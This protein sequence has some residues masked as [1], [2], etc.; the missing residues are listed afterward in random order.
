MKNYPVIRVIV[1][2]ICGIILQQFITVGL[3]FF[4]VI[5]FLA[6]V[7]YFIY[8]KSLA[9]IKN[10]MI[11]LLINTLFILAG[12]H[13][14]E[15]CFS[16]RQFY[17]GNIEK[18]NSFTL[19][20]TVE[21][22]YLI[23]KSGLRFEIN[24]DSASVNKFM[25][26]RR[27][28]LICNVKDE[29]YK[30][31][32]SLYSSV[33]PG[34]KI[35]VSGTLIKGRSC[36][37]PGEFDY[38]K[39]LHLYGITG[40]LNVY[41]SDDFKILDHS[42]NWCSDLLF[43]VRKSIAEKLSLYHDFDAAS[44][45]KGLLLADRSEMNDE[46]KIEFVNAGVVHVLAVSGLNVEYILLL[47]IILLGRLNIYPKSFLTILCLIL[48]L[49]ITGIQASVFRAILMSTM[50]IIAYIT[51][52]STNVINSLA[53][54]ALILLTFFP[55]YLYDPGFQL[56]YAAVLSM[57]VIYPYFHRGI[58]N[59]KNKVLKIF[60]QLIAL[61]LS[62]QIGTIP[63]T[64][65]YFG[66]LSITSL[67]ANLIVIPFIGILVGIGIASLLS[68]Y[69]SPF[70]A[71]C[72]G[73][74]NSL[75]TKLLYFIVHIS[76]GENYSFIWIRNFSLYDSIV[77]Y[78][79]LIALMYLYKRFSNSTARL[80]LIVFLI[81]DYITISSFDNRDLLTK[82]KM[83]LMMI[84]VGQGDSFLIKFPNGE[85]ALIDAGD[86]SMKFDNGEKIILPLMNHL[87]IP[88]V[89]YAFVSHIDS[90]HYGGFVSLIQAG[91]IKRIYKPEL[92]TSLSR[93]IKFEN[94]IKKQNI[95]IT[96]YHKSVI[97]IGNARIFVLN[98]KFI[99][100]RKN[101]SN[102]DKSSLLKVLYGKTSFLFT[103][104]LGINAEK[105][106]SSLYN[107]NLRSDV[108]KVSHHGSKYCSSL[109]ILNYIQP[110]FALISAG[111]KNKFN[112]PSKEVLTR[113]R[114][115]HANIMRSD[116]QGAVL[117]KSDGNAVSQIN[118]KDLY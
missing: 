56:S 80:L 73:S 108:L 103:G 23:N 48:F 9:L 72:Y 101:N 107:F 11:S 45:M 53:L 32:D 115:F 50:V 67:A 52:R 87:N 59:I 17:S 40:I 33:S 25:L 62:A 13:S 15:I 20:G 100:F 5:Y 6:L 16:E 47:C 60:A 37:N 14:S 7:S 113:L 21:S 85:T 8:K 18:E 96:Y 104:D 27:V 112:H 116:K 22:I 46:T 102:N 1:F 35:C 55:Y 82:N 106:Y 105:Y 99:H 111:I 117:L 51:S 4:V 38:N 114:M 81:A 94:F 36:R 43:R 79:L 97:K 58:C 3:L 92:D 90:D 66:K 30:K 70:T 78:L 69:F 84:D 42:K 54:S 68:S 26:H 110:H 75:L 83:N 64:L 65:Y 39:Y 77:F 2:F 98:N 28:I 31:L 49:F 24:A 10:L 91:R 74:I 95:P 44:L 19:Y 118:W 71:I 86:A 41:N 89:D 76:G 29:N 109:N 12:N 57:A 63:F 61:S 88:A 34:N 93:D